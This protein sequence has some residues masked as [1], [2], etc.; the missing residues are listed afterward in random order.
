MFKR[1]SRLKRLWLH[2]KKEIALCLAS[3]LLLVTLTGCASKQPMLSV[4][5]P[6][7]VQ[8][9]ATLKE[10]SLPDAR[11]Y[12]AEAQAWFDEVSTFLS[13]LR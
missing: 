8:V 5:C 6:Q 10:S 9:P 12:S 1:E 13:G 2:G 11:T 3:T 4:D 7:P